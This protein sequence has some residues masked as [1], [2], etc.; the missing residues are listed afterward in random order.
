MIRRILNQVASQHVDPKEKPP[1]PWDDG[2]AE[3]W[4]TDGF[5]SWVRFAVPGMLGDGNLVASAWAMERLPSEGDIVEIGSFCGLSTIMLSALR[6]R[7]GERE[8]RIITSDKWQFEGQALGSTLGDSEVTHETYQNFVR[9]SYIRNV[10]TFCNPLPITVSSLSDEFFHYWESG[11]DE[12]D[13]VSG[14]SVV[15]GGPIGFAYIDGN[16]TYDYAKRDY[17]N[18][19]RYLVSGGW[20]MFDDSADGSG[21][22]VNRLVRE[23]AENSNYELVAKAPNYLFRKR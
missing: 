4:L 17:E 6:S 10:Q 1:V 16:H 15:L 5:I 3:R 8:R 21:W 2:Y 12:K 11:A 13:V 9:D 23:L 18:V 7:F 22:E 19:D 14:H 20:I